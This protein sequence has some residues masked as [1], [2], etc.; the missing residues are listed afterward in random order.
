V[1]RA[2]GKGR[3]KE[4]RNGERGEE[5]ARKWRRLTLLPLARIPAGDHNRGP[6]IGSATGRTPEVNSNE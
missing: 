5:M 1:D 2:R 4:E 3:G 6:E